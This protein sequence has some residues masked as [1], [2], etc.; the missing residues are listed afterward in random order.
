MPETYKRL[1]QGQ[2]ALAVDASN[3]ILYACPAD[4][5]A[6]IRQMIFSN[7]DASAIHALTLYHIDNGGTANDTKVILKA[8]NIESG[9]WADFTGTIILEAQDELRGL[10]TLNDAEATDITY[11]LYGL[12]LS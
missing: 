10:C 1:G 9:G 5:T 7:V 11:V 12:E 6:I 4:T 2:V 8:A 3:G